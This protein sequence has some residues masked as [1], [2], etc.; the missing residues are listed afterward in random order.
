VGGGVSRQHAYRTSFDGVLCE[1][2]QT[3]RGCTSVLMNVQS[4]ISAIMITCEIKSAII[5]NSADV[6]FRNGSQCGK[7]KFVVYLQT[8]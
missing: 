4:L 2:D 6:I 3:P 5:F 8:T 1:G 7:L